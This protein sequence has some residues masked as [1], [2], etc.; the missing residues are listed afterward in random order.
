M[1]N[2]TA[3]LL[4]LFLI[5]FVVY[6]MFNHNDNTTN[7]S[8][9][10]DKKLVES[11]I[12]KIYGDSDKVFGGIKN[13][14]IY[15]DSDTGYKYNKRLVY[16][17]STSQ[18]ETNPDKRIVFL[19]DNEV[20]GIAIFYNDGRI[21][22]DNIVIPKPESSSEI[23]EP[24]KISLNICQTDSENKDYWSKTNINLF[25]QPGSIVAG[26]T[27]VGDLPSCSSIN[28]DVLDKEIVDGV[29]FYKVKYNNIVGWQ[30][31]RLLVGD[32]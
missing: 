4:C 2:K 9:E 16:Y 15:E 31:K 6:M 11:D 14:P 18:D 21:I 32:N 26:A 23:M 13:S 10:I 3:V 30:T 17:L 5:M 25:S 7:L 20:K 27:K 8:N 29:E 19:V 22:K 12:I 24:E 28:L 1:S